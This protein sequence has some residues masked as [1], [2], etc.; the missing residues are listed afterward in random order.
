LDRVFPLHSLFNP[1]SLFKAPI[2]RNRK[3]IGVKRF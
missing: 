2:D 1:L 3:N